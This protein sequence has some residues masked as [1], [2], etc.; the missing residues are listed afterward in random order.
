MVTITAWWLREAA[1]L[2]GIPDRAS[3]NEIRARYSERIREWHPDVPQIRRS[4]TR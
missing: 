2:L 4:P 1:D 3:L